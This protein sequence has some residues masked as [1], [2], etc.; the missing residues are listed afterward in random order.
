MKTSK[1]GIKFISGFEGLS[2]KAYKCDESE[3]YWTIGYG[4]YGKDVKKGDVITK[5]RAL[6]L[7][8]ADLKTAEKAV[9][10]GVKKGYELSQTEYDALVSFCYNVGNIKQVTA[11]YSRSKKE[12]A[13]AML[14]YNKCNGKVLN[15]LTRRRKAENKL[16]LKG[17]YS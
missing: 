5:E 9:N 4:H 17:V 7:L 3:K 13:A 16:F 12:I 2:L 6:Q 11:N 15:G 10:Y 14:K 1:K 8:A